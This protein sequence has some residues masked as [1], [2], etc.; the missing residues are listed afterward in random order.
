MATVPELMELGEL[1]A[2][3]GF[4]LAAVG[5]CVRDAV[6]GARDV[7]DVDLT[8]DATPEQALAMLDG[9]ADA[10]WDVGIRWGTVGAR[11]A[12][13]SWEITTYL[14]LIHI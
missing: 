10:V 2:T 9:W 1:F 12:E 14:S 8:T 4:E 6:L 3:A 5:G 13:R 7:S 11:K